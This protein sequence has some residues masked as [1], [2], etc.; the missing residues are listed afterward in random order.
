MKYKVPAKGELKETLNDIQF[1]VTQ[2]DYTEPP[3]QNEFWDHT[4]DGIY[5]DIVTGEPL[6]SSTHK[7][8]A[9]C[10]WPSFYKTIDEEVLMEKDDFSIAGRPRVE[11]RSKHANSHLGHVFEDGPAPS[12]KRWCINSVALDFVPKGESK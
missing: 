10:G 3:F 5:V 11:V 6:F 8:D 12:G 9:G 2:E 4:E 1:K 7:Y